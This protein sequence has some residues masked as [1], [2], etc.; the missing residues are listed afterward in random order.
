MQIENQTWEVE[1]GDETPQRLDKALTQKLPEKLGISRSRISKMIRA[2]YVWRGDHQETEPDTKTQL[3]DIWTIRFKKPVADI[4][5]AEDIPLNILYEDDELIVINKS[6]GLV[7]HPARGNWNGT[8]VNA[9]LHHC[10]D[11]IRT[12]GRT[13]RPGIVHRLDKDTS[14]VMVVAKTD[15][16]ML[17]LTDQLY[18]RLVERRYHAIVKGIPSGRGSVNSILNVSYEEN[19][20]IR[21]ECSIGRHPTR[22]NQMTIMKEG[23]RH[24]VTRIRV[25]KP[26]ANCEA[27][28][29]ECKLE[30]GRTHQIRVHLKALGHALIGDQTYGVSSRLLPESAGER[31]RDAAIGFPRQALHAVSLGLN[32]PLTKEDMLF[33]S[34]YPEDIKSLLKTLIT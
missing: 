20:W 32:H 2:G 18:K 22:R 15:R 17:R 9:L 24:A 26:L 7:V 16:A 3:G 12:L 28:L 8:L 33:K 10:G 11:S 27:A 31:A 34:E 13:A 14:G 21:I 19:D 4:L 30:T 23:G 6:A 29:V 25:V 1:I 5:H